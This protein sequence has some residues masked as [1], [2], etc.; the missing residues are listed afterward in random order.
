MKIMVNPGDVV[1]FDE[2]PDTLDFEVKGV[3]NWINVHM[4]TVSVE[5]PG[6]GEVLFSLDGSAWSDCGQ[7]KRE[8]MFVLWNWKEIV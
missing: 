8:T 7:F 1:S 4:N 6:W 2:K 3:V 5:V